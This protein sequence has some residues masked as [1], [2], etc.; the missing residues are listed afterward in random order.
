MN[1]ITRAMN[2]NALRQVEPL[3]TMLFEGEVNAHQFVI[4]PAAGVSF[5]GAS[6]TAYFVRSD[7]QRVNLTGAV[8]NGNAVVTISGNCCAVA[9]RYK[10]TIFA[11]T[12]DETAA[13]YACA[14]TVHGTRG[15]EVAGDTEPIVEPPVN[16]NAITDRLDVLDSAY[17]EGVDLTVKFADEIANYSDEWAWIKARI[18]ARNFNG[19]HIG[20]YIPVTCTN[21][22]VFNA[23]IAGINTYRYRNAHS[24]LTVGNKIFSDHID[25]I[26]DRKWPY[27]CQMNK[28]LFNNGLQN[29]QSFSL[30]ESTN[31]VVLNKWFPFIDKS[32]PLTYTVNSYDP[33][34]QTAVLSRNMTGSINLYCMANLYPWNVSNAYYFINSLK[35][36]VPNGTGKDPDLVAVDYSADG[37]YYHLPASLK[38]VITEKIVYHPKRYSSSSSGVETDD[39]G[40]D[41]YSIGKLWLPSEVEVFGRSIFGTKVNG[42]A[43]QM[44]YPLFRRFGADGLI[45]GNTDSMWTLS[46]ESGSDKFISIEKGVPKA[47]NAT[48]N[49][50]PNVCFRIARLTLY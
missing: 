38:A 21:N 6:V 25:F 50:Y 33:D 18:Q 10:L 26:S 8:E 23:R 41:V 40:Y 28:A 20:D 22:S 3:D 43:G 39:N 7:T 5:E 42:D 17:Y 45:C 46:T 44:Q 19:L 15:S 34:T 4:T 35:G 37:I 36:K 14:G 16:L 27:A 24:G 9:G 29:V 32:S 13:I 47:S 49:N 12:A 30:S 31:T 48:V 11:V 2:A 1:I